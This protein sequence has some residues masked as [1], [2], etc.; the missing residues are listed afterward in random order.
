MR[1][2]HLIVGVA[3]F[4]IFAVTGQ[5][6][7]ADFPDKEA[8][9]Q[10][11]RLLMRSRH[12]YILFSALIHLTLAAYMRLGPVKPA[13]IM[14]LAGSGFLLI[15]SV[16]LVR[17]FIVETYSAHQFTDLSRSGIYASLAGVALHLIGGLAQKRV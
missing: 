16:Y 2:L 8:I 13:K 12:I 15:A 7:R 17:A 3:M 4:V 14:Q 11:F 5:Y 10:D 6:M 1:W 9:P